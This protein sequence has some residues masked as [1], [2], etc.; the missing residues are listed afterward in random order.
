MSGLKDNVKRELVLWN[1]ITQRIWFNSIRSLSSEIKAALMF[2]ITTQRL[3]E[4]ATLRDEKL[5]R[6][7]FEAMIEVVKKRKKL[8]EII[9][10][11]IGAK[12]EYSKID[13][14]WVLRYGPELFPDS[15]ND[16]FENERKQVYERMMDTGMRTRVRSIIDNVGDVNLDNPYET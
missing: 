11:N 12:E 10:S 6:N 8:L 2:D 13:L 9:V 5:I 15:V 3:A 4:V 7:S 16:C 1:D 14:E